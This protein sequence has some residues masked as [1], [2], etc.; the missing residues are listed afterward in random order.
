MFKFSSLANAQGFRNKATKP[1][2]IIQGDNNK[3]WV[4]SMKEGSK[5][6]KQGY[7]VVK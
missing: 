5:L 2:M 3:F 1:M 6:Q 7:E 4:V